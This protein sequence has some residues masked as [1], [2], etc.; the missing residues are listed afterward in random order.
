[1]SCAGCEHLLQSE[2]GK[3]KGILE[4]SVSYDKG[5]TVV[6]FDETEI[7]ILE[8]TVTINKIGYQVTSHKIL[9]M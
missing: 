6:K 2:V 5:N 3:L 7:S 8:I 9:P 4:V 1:M